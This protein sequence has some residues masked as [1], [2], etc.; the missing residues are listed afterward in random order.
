L[1][2]WVLLVA[3]SFFLCWIIRD[4][5]RLIR[6]MENERILNILFVGPRTDYG[7][8]I[9]GSSLLS[10]R[11]SGF[12]IYGEDLQSEY[13]WGR[14]PDRFDEGLLPEDSGNR[15]GRYSLPDRAG[16]S[17]RFIIRTGP[18]A[19]RAPRSGPPG[20]APP[21]EPPPPIPGRAEGEGRWGDRDARRVFQRP[22]SLGMPL[23]NSRYISIDV[24]HPAFWRTRLITAILFPLISIGLLFLVFY[25]RT[26][27]LR[28]REYRDRI[29]VQQNLVVLGTAA[30]TLAHEIKNP[31][32]SIR[33]Q[34]G[35]L[36]RMIPDTGSGELAIIEEEVGRLADLSYRVGDF[37]REA[38]G[39]AE[40]LNLGALGE[41]TFRRLLG[42]GAALGEVWVRMDRERARSVLENLLRNALE[43]GGDPAE[44][45]VNLHSAQG[46]V[47]LEIV[48][49]GKGIAP[50]ALERIFDPF[51]TSKSTGTG[52]GL[53]I[54]KR[55]VEAAGGSI[56][57]ENRGGGGVTALVKLPA[58]VPGESA[59]AFARHPSPPR[60]G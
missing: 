10:S 52:I 14:V 22:E 6:D 33:L 46:T 5:S 1:L 11:I 47:I 39:N 55:F 57:L 4:R 23:L 25:I 8:A 51:F 58:W 40:A 32:L 38:E 27:Y 44:I 49:R 34:T 36:R 42:R 24:N 50:E 9:E 29:E 7:A 26:L 17:I 41:E 2:S 20:D 59:S 30:S 54:S 53:A 45:G 43:A 28:T 37:L 18:P 60:Q 15:F 16:R 3:L 21:P 31:L 48:D 19:P 13:A 12:A 35:L 56:S